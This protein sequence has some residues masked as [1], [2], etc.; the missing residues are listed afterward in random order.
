MFSTPFCWFS[1]ILYAAYVQMGANGCKFMFHCT[2]M[3]PPI[4]K[5]VFNSVQKNKPISMSQKVIRPCKNGQINYLHGL[6]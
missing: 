2:L 3:L 1:Y 5:V 4:R 6:R